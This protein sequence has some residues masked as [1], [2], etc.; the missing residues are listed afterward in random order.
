LSPLTSSGRCVLAGSGA[1]GAITIT[2]V[3][4]TFSGAFGDTTSGGNITQIANF[5]IP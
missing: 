1:P 4:D 3:Y 2:A 5:V